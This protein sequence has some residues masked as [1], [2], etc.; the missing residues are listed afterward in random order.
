M[1]FEEIRDTTSTGSTL[2]VVRIYKEYFDCW[3]IGD[4]SIKLYDEGGLV[5]EM[6][7][8]SSTNEKEIARL[9]EQ[10]IRITQEQ[11]PVVLTPDTITYMPAYRIN[12]SPKDSIALTHS[13]GHNKISGDFIC[14][15][16]IPRE[17][18]KLY[19]M[20][21]ASD[22]FWDMVC[23]T[24][25]PILLDRQKN[26]NANTLLWWCWYR[27]TQL[28]N[29]LEDGKVQKSQFPNNNIDDICLAL[30]DC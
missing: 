16:H 15:K 11:K 29:H 21:I 12:L 2:S 19:R 5:W 14:H 28:W 24:D 1:N 17:T 18:N 10:K 3:W 6:E 23:E 22:G 20:I 30:V 9:K 4:S 25:T 27:W 8:H 7:A 26:D 13:I